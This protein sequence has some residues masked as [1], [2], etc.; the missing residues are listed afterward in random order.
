MTTFVDGPQHWGRMASNL[1]VKRANH[2][3]EHDMRER[4]RKP[5]NWHSIT[6]KIDN[7]CLESTILHEV[8]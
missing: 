2:M 3:Q 6:R 7:H 1:M 8:N 4:N 5:C